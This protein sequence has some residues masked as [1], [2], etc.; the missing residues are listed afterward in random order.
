MVL[1]AYKQGMA[2]AAFVIKKR[3]DINVHLKLILIQMDIVGNEW[4]WNCVKIM[5]LKLFYFVASRL[6]AMQFWEIGSFKEVKKRIYNAALIIVLNVYYYLLLRLK[7]WQWLPAASFK[8]R[9]LYDFHTELKYS[10]ESETGF[11]PN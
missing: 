3:K 11:V 9:V 1:A 6:K 4:V 5:A 7:Y 2:S 10:G 8:W